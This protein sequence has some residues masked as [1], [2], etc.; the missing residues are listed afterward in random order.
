MGATRPASG[1]IADQITVLATQRLVTIIHSVHAATTS[2][3]TGNV[4][5]HV[6]D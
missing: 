6:A 3:T 2:S 5:E 1:L 4:A